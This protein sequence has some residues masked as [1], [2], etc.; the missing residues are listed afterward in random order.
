MRFAWLALVCVL[1]AETAFAHDLWIAH[2]RYTNNK[3]GE[4]CCGQDDCVKVAEEDVKVTPAGYLLRSGEV[5]PYDET[6][7]SEDGQYWRC[8]RFDRAKT[9]RCFFAPNPASE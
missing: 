6:M 3:T 4:L 5:V 7:K 2:G 8:H 9:R 1:G